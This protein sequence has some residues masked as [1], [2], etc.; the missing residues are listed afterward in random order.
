MRIRKYKHDTAARHVHI[1]IPSFRALSVKKKS[2]N[3]SFIFPN[4]RRSERNV[5]SSRRRWKPSRRNNC[6]ETYYKLITLIISRSYYFLCADKRIFPM[7]FGPD[8]VSVK[9][10]AFLCRNVSECGKQGL[11]DLRLIFAA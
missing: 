4:R 10:R 11:L 6:Y 2:V 7:G 5:K 9:T 3:T 1:T 8:G